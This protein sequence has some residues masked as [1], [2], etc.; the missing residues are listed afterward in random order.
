M[1]I[2]SINIQNIKKWAEEMMNKS[3][4]TNNGT[5]IKEEKLSIE[6]LNKIYVIL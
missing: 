4:M 5:I 3:K 2:R 1:Y 6:Y